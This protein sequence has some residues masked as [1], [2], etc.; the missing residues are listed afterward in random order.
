MPKNN[1]KYSFENQRESQ[2]T[3]PEDENHIKPNSEVYINASFQPSG[4]DLVSF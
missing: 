3:K 2:M 1:R 4:E